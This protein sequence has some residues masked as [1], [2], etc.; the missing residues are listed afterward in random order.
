MYFLSFKLYR[1]NIVPMLAPSLTFSLH[2]LLRIKTWVRCNLFHQGTDQLCSGI[3][4]VALFRCAL[5]FK[6]LAVTDLNQPIFGLNPVS[7]RRGHRVKTP[8]PQFLEL[9]VFVFVFDF[10]FVSMFVFV[11][12]FVFAFVFV[13][14]CLFFSRDGS[15]L[16]RDFISFSAH[17]AFNYLP[18][19][20]AKRFHQVH[21][22]S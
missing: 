3:S 7:P 14:V 22:I 5:I 9:V 6:L 21:L 18:P 8:P 11:F 13:F 12:L 20:W 15:T 4:S 1:A 2:E 16:Q 10:L 19:V 17:K